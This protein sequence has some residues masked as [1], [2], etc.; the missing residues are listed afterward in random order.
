MTIA[1][2]PLIAFA[3][4]A[5]PEVED[6]TGAG[7]GVPIGAADVEAD[8]ARSGGRADL[9]LGARDSDGVPVGEADHEADKRASG[10]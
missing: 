7:A 6:V 8:I 1:Q 10:A 4:A 3:L 2:N 5:K 9:T